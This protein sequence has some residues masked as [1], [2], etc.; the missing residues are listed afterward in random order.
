M[1]LSNFCPHYLSQGPSIPFFS[2]VCFY[3]QGITEAT[4]PKLTVKNVYY[5]S[6]KDDMCRFFEL[7]TISSCVV[8]YGDAW[9]DRD[10]DI[11]GREEYLSPYLVNYF[12]SFTSRWTKI[13]CTISFSGNKVRFFIRGEQN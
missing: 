4:I 9:G 3:V 12:L 13:L 6:F 11:R 7:P 5:Q 8:A 1:L 2:T 10:P